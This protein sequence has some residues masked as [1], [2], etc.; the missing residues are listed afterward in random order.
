[1]VQEISYAR[2]ADVIRELESMDGL[3]ALVWLSQGVREEVKSGWQQSRTVG[4]TVNRGAFGQTLFSRDDLSAAGEYNVSAG[5]GVIFL[6]ASQSHSDGTDGQPDAG[7]LWGRLDDGDRLVV[8]LSGD[9][10]VKEVLESAVAFFDVLLDGTSTLADALEAGTAALGSGATLV[11]NAYEP[12]SVTWLE[13]YDQIWD[14]VGF[15]PSNVQAVIP[16]TATPYCGAP[17]ATKT[18]GDEGHTQPFADVV[19]DGPFFEGNRVTELTGL[20]VDVTIRGVVTGFNEGDRVLVEVFGN[21]DDDYRGYHAFGE[22]TIRE[23]E[24]DDE[25]VYTVHF[26]GAAHTSPYDNSLGEECVLNNP[27]ISTT[28]SVRAKL[29]MTP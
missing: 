22:G 28:T 13:G 5:P 15:T 4:L 24:L 11:S 16:I 10:D 1:E 3:D 9:A 27:Q 23:V 29:V 2:E 17:G 12:S 14:T 7:S 25:G 20:S 21:F 8:G 18:A 26:N 19:F 6:A